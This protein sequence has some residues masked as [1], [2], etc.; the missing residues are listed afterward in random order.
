M[1]FKVVIPARYSST[2]L[3]AKP[4]VDLGGRPMIQWVVDACVSQ[5]C[6]RSAGGDR[7]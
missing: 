5:R 1:G 7:R 4:L 3:P 6:R 2:R